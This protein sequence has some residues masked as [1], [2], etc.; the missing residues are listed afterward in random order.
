MA[1]R[2]GARDSLT[3]DIPRRTG[4]IFNHNGLAKPG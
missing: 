4:A 3:A 1:V 2:C